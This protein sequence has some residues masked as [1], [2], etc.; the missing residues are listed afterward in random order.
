MYDPITPKLLHSR[1]IPTIYG[2]GASIQIFLTV[3]F[4]A[5]TSTL[6]PSLS[7]FV[8]IFV[9]TM[10]GILSSREMMAAWEVNPPSSVTIAEDFFIA[11]T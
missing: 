7:T 6:S 10:Q 2:R 1:G 9:P 3:P 5:S 4:P 8:A 11:E